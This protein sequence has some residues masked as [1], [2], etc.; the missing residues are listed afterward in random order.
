MRKP[1]TCANHTH[2]QAVLSSKGRAICMDSM[3]AFSTL[4]LSLSTRASA[5][6]LHSHMRAFDTLESYHSSCTSTAPDGYIWILWCW[7]GRPLI[8][9]RS[10]RPTLSI[11]CTSLEASRRSSQQDQ[12]LARTHFEMHL[13]GPRFKTS[14]RCVT[15]FI[16]K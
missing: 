3:L 10:S 9:D 1:Y 13:P 2:A 16:T 7:P 15:A 11:A 5:H 6:D 4:S 8:T 12:E 14:M